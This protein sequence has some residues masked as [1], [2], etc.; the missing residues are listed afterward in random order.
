MRTRDRNFFCRKAAIWQLWAAV[1]GPEYP[2]FSSR[3]L[4]D[5]PDTT[6]AKKSIFFDAPENALTQAPIQPGLDSCGKTQQFKLSHAPTFAQMANR[7]PH[8]SPIFGKAL[9]AQKLCAL[10]NC[11]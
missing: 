1:T 9:E 10:S 7:Q 3:E 8:F 5:Q 11:S 4:P 6:C 2:Y